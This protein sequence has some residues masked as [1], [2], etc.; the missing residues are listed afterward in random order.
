ME[1][2]AA[3]TRTPPAP[4]RGLAFCGIAW[5]LL[6]SCVALLATG[7]L[8]G[9]RVST[10]DALQRAVA[11][12]DVHSV[13][14]TGGM[15]EAFRG[16]QSVTV[17]WQEGAV[18]HQAPLVEQHPLRWTVT[19]QGLPVVFSVERDLAWLD[20]GVSIERRP[21]EY[22]DYN[23]VYGWRL[24]SWTSVATLVVGLGG[25]LLLIAG[26]QPRRATR[27]AWFWMMAAAPPLGFV[28]FLALGSSLSPRPRPDLG[29]RLTGGRAFLL[30][31]LVGGALSALATA[32]L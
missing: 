28:A 13:V 21:H 9:E 4:L 18:H 31:V 7:L 17:H 22:P 25:V 15:S 16:R 24:P 2:I 3:P 11:R 10:Y 12:G 27:W 30:S 20:R 23:E 6:L 14:V 8:V 19:R 26:P 5:A 32:I 1:A 29:R